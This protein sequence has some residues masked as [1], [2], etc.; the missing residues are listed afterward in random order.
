MAAYGRR[1]TVNGRLFRGKWSDATVNVHTTWRGLRR[2]RQTK[3]R[4]ERCGSCIDP[5]DGPSHP[6]IFPRSRLH[7]GIPFER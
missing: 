2:E 7:S 1:L 4:R 6:Y 3:E 5:A